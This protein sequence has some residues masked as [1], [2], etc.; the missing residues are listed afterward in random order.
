MVNRSCACP[1]DPSE[2]KRPFSVGEGLR[3]ALRL[4]GYR[5]RFSFLWLIA[6]RTA[7]G[8]CDLL[9]AGA[10]YVLFLSLQGA[11]LAHHRWWMPRTTLSAA[12][13]TACLV[14]CRTLMDLLS[15]QSLVGHIQKLYTDLLLRL[16]NGYNEMQWS[17]FTQRNRSELLNHAMYTA[18]EAAMFYHYV[19]ETIA[20][21]GVV[22]A[23]TAAIVYQSPVAA[24]GLGIV[25]LLLYAVHRFLIRKEVRRA[26]S[27]REHSL[28]TLQRTLADMFSSGKEIRS[29]GIQSFFHDRIS[30]QAQSSAASHVRVALLPQ[31][32]RILTD[33]GV[34]LLFLCIVIAVQLHHGDARQMLS[35]LVFYFVLSRRLLPLISQISFTAGQMEGS[36]KNVQLVSDELNDCS[37]YRTAPKNVSVPDGDLVIELDEVSFLF[38][39]GA[40]ILRNVTLWLRKGEIAVLRGISGTGKS[41]L[42][43]LLAGV[44]QPASGFVRVDHERVAYVPQDIVLL[45]DSIRNNLL[46]GLG[47][48]TNAELMDAL[49]VA[50]L[51]TFVVGL[52]LGLDTEVGDNGVLLSGGQRQRIGLA[53]AILRGAS[54]LLLD[55]ATSALDE[56]SECQVLKNLSASG[57]AVL[58]ATHRVRGWA[59]A[60]RVFRLQEGSLIEEEIEELPVPYVQAEPA[61]VEC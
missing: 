59:F 50:H 42:L 12:S 6:A 17:R 2:E 23:M 25:A 21:V 52:P 28:R 27:A 18:R 10:M 56:E 33:Q 11:S 8:L 47:A 41:S 54:L 53:R 20:A 36:Y 46:F 58:L 51:E 49:A 16:T 5:E 48:K 14:V 37:L 1:D 19:I 44:L 31:V 55:E 13:L 30:D 29:Y 7:V 32:A 60:Q 39:E 3:P 24:F 38:S 40:P 35:L 26:V 34:V 15:T 4:V 9:L 45:D 61:G 57:V 22:T 43:N